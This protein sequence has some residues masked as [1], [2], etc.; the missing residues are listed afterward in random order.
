M[1]T[2]IFGVI[3]GGLVVFVVGSYFVV[4]ELE[5]LWR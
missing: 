3:I 5:K 1:I 4:K 2:L